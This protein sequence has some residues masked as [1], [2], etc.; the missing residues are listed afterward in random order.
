MKTGEVESNLAVLNENFK[1]SYIPDLINQKLTGKEQAVLKETDLEFHQRESD[2]LF[3]TLETASKE[4]HL[5][6][7]TAAK[8]ELNDFLVRIRMASIAVDS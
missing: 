3:E 6:K 8:E 1:L 5:P 2:R 4:T 7:E